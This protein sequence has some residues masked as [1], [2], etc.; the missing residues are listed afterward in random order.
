MGKQ[1]EKPEET[2]KTS[3]AESVDNARVYPRELYLDPETSKFKPGNPGKLKGQKDLSPR[4]LAKKF[5]AA[6]EKIGGLEGLAGWAETS[7]SSR[8]EFYRL[9]SKLFPKGIDLHVEG[10]ITWEQFIRNIEGQGDEG[11]ENEQGA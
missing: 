7:P 2:K 4:G 1:E 5:L 9:A 10:H 8:Q 6:F 11:D 3:D